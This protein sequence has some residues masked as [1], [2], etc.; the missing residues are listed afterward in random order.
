LPDGTVSVDAA[1]SKEAMLDHAVAKQQE[2]D[3]Q[4][5]REEKLSDPERR[6]RSR[7]GCRI[8]ISGHLGYLFASRVAA[9]NPPFYDPLFPRRFSNLPVP[10]ICSGQ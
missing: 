6:L 9:V 8:R 5:D 10:P 2:E 7:G 4:E 3:C 1:A